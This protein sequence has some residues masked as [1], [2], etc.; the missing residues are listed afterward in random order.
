[1]DV[2]ELK[3]RTA[4]EVLLK[5][6]VLHITHAFAV[7]HFTSL[8]SME[9]GLQALAVDFSILHPLY[10]P[11]TF[12]VTV[13]RVTESYCVSRTTDTVTRGGDS[14][15]HDSDDEGRVPLD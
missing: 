13:F 10:L 12:F 3:L 11:C 6:F 15:Q 1:M 14:D 4:V 8:L 5:F 7:G 9:P 2:D